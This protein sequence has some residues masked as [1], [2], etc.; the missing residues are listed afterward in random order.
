MDIID[1]KIIRELQNNA[2][3]SNQELAEKV[4][5]SPSPCLRRVRSLEKSGILIGY[6]AQVDQ[7]QFG[8]PINAFVS[9]RLEKQDHTSV[10]NFETCINDLDEVMECY[11]MTG[12]R[13]YQMR[14]V[15]ADLKSYERFIREKLTCLPGLASIES[16]FAFGNVKNKNVFPSVPLA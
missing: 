5:L 9:I 6:T 10:Q 1:R 4:N 13:D 14:V 2:R 15:S 16:S 7:E 12:S 11:L 8:L 3:L